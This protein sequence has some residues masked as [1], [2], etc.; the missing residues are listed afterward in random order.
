MGN[1]VYN[2]DAEMQLKDAGAVT[3]TAAA[4]VGGSDKI[5]DL[6]AARFEGT[7]VV[8]ASAIDATTGDETYDVTIE[9]SNSATFASGVVELASQKVAETGRHEIFFTN[10]KADTTY[11]YLRAKHVL[12]GT[13][14]SINYTAW[15]A[16]LPGC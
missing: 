9:G 4:Q 13:T 12:G 14:P 7:V 5:Q 2:F 15:V 10:Q 11:R 3:A 6:G 8:D 1:R 16:P